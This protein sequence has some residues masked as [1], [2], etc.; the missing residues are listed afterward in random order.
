[1]NN[2]CDYLW[3]GL[4]SLRMPN[5]GGG[6]GLGTSGA[7]VNGGMVGTFVTGLDAGPSSARH[8]TGACLLYHNDCDWLWAGIN[9]LA[10]VVV[11]ISSEA[12]AVGLLG[13]WAAA[14]GNVATNFVPGRGACL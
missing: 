6:Q 11:G 4:G 14:I 8:M 1:M 10:Y 2:D 5:I 13:P 7:L 3:I 9:S 12:G